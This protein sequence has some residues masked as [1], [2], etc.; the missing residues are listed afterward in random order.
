MGKVRS[1]TLRGTRARAFFWLLEGRMRI[2]RCR[3]NRELT[4]SIKHPG[5][6]FGEAGLTG[7]N[8]NAWAQAL[9]PARVAIMGR[10]ALRRLAAEKPAIGAAMIEFLVERM[11]VYEDML[12]E[13]SLKEIPCRLA[14]LLVRCVE[15]EGEAEEKGYVIPHHYNHQILASMI[16]C[17][18]PALTRAIRD[19]SEAGIILVSDHRIHVPDLK[20]LARYAEEG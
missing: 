12:D 10:K 5:D 19:L 6:F 4:L 16:G 7:L 3:K 13:I 20:V 9:D 14:S 18:R 1:S 17:E 2:Y 8:Q 15:D 11:G